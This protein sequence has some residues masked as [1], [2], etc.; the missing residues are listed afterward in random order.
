MLYL[1][2]DSQSC[3]HHSIEYTV[4]QAILGGV[5]YVQLREK[6]LATK[7][8]LAIGRRLKPLLK[9]HQIP[10]IIN[11]RVDIAQALD[12]DGVHLGQDD[13]PYQQARRLLGKDKIIG[14]TVE[15]SQQALA[16]NQWD[17]DY[18]GIGPIF[19]TIT[20][21]DAPEPLGI[22]GLKAISTL[23]RHSMIAI[24]GINTIN[25]Q[26]VL[27]VGV[28]GVAVV[29]AICSAHDPRQA[30]LAFATLLAEQGMQ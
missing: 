15:T 11:D 20:K 21:L 30:S 12:A 13:M 1:I 19:A 18:I 3:Q 27:T 26:Q 7:D 5:N 4:E 28:Q 17:V 22:S 16:A 8:I 9:R 10:F 6:N 24:G 23:S 29:S 14:L 25:L 2:V